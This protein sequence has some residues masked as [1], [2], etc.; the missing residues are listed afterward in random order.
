MLT[1]LYTRFNAYDRGPGYIGVSNCYRLLLVFS[2][3]VIVKHYGKPARYQLCSFDAAL[4][5]AVDEKHTPR[6]SVIIS[7]YAHKFK[8]VI[9]HTL[10]Y[11]LGWIVARLRALGLQDLLPAIVHYYL[12]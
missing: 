4:A 7:E 11:R 5:H 8:R 6:E 2:T 9:A 1:T 12:W 10:M 3:H